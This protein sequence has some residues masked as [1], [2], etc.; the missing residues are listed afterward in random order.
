MIEKGYL[1]SEKV[2]NIRNRTQF[3]TTDASAQI[4][5]IIEE[6]ADAKTGEIKK[7]IVLT[8]TAQQFII[9]N[10]DNILL[11]KSIEWMILKK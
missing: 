6:K 3:A 5:I 4:G 7:N 11:K 10:L 8:N 9:D 2:A 1:I